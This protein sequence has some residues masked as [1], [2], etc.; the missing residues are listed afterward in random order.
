MGAS[1]LCFHIQ[2]YYHFQVRFFTLYT[3]CVSIF[4]FFPSIVRNASHLQKSKVEKPQKKKNMQQEERDVVLCSSINK[5]CP[6]LQFEQPT[7]NS[8]KQKFD[9]PSFYFRPRPMSPG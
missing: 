8:A 2:L 1:Y 6:K 4:A 9:L 7:G 3:I 5:A